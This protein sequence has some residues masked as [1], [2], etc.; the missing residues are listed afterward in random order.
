MRN[1][2]KLGYKIVRFI[3]LKLVLISGYIVLEACTTPCV[4]KCYEGVQAETI[5]R[6]IAGFKNSV[7]G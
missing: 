1:F 2:K 6:L 4:R 7:G 5:Y 3:L